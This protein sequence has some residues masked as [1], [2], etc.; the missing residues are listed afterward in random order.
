MVKVDVIFCKHA[1]Q[2]L[3]TRCRS[4][5]AGIGYFFWAPLSTICVCSCW[6][7]REKI[8]IVS[9]RWSNMKERPTLPVSLKIY[10]LTTT[11]CILILILNL[12]NTSY[13]RIIV[14]IP[15][16]S[17]P[18]PRRWKRV[19]RF[20]NLPANIIGYHSLWRYSHDFTCTWSLIRI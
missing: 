5:R 4:F 10:A 2:E 18:L 20:E 17:T 14:Y 7:S 8:S 9:E 11:R 16:S 13:M 3:R 19:G 15:K 12:R 6:W 1:S